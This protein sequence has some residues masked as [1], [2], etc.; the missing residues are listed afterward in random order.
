M[1]R[2]T[3]VMQGLPI[4]NLDKIKITFFNE[5][6]ELQVITTIVTLSLNFQTFFFIAF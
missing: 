6:T 1:K 4:L 2:Q 5:L 3:Y